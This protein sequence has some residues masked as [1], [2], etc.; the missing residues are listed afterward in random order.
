[1]TNKPPDFLAQL[2]GSF[3]KP[4]AENPTVAMV[5]AAYRHHGLNWRYINCEVPPELL[6]DAVRGAKAMGWAGFNCSIPNKIA[7]IQY[8]DG[9]GES[10]QII[11]AVNTV[12]RR[13]DRYIGE[14]T[15]GRGFVSALRN[16]IDPAGK[17]V[18][19]FG[20]GGAA[21]AVAV[22][23]SLA[24]AA[25]ISVV[26]RDRKRGE[27][28]ARLLNDKTAAKAEAVAWTKQYRVPDAA[29]IVINNTSVGLY[30]DVEARLDVDVDS[31]KPHMVVADGIPNPPRTRW[32]RD[33]EARGCRVMDGLAM[34]VAQ[35]IIAIKY[36][37]GIDADVA[38]MRKA[39]EEALSL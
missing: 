23:M 28:L 2:T 36:W 12:V 22:E 39:L 9:L 27:E 21:R 24:G 25:Q 31:L 30:P 17:T 20:A 18:V 8:L 1:M 3:A 16:L 33:A 29:D 13:D 7:V 15:D 37:T 19:L 11:G 6:G 35:G 38:V 32:I 14:N 4:A 26:N 10:A 5:E 34:L